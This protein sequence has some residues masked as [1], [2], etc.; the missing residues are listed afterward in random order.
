MMAHFGSGTSAMFDEDVAEP[1]GHDRRAVH[2]LRPLRQDRASK[3]AFGS[4]FIVAGSALQDSELG[5]VANARAR[6]VRAGARRVHE[7]RRARPHAASARSARKCRTS[8]T[9]SSLRATRTSSACRSARSS[10]SFDQDA[11]A[12]WNAN[13]EEGLDDRQGDRRQGGVVGPR[14]RCRPSTC[15][16]GTIMGTGAGEF[17]DQQLRPDPRD[18]QSLDRRARHLPDRAA[19]RTRPTRSSPCRCA[20]PSTSGEVGQRGG[21]GG[22]GAQPRRHWRSSR[23]RRDDR[24]GDVSRARRR[25]EHHR[26]ATSFR[27][28]S[29]ERDAA[30]TPVRRGREPRHALGASRSARG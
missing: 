7:A 29:G 11:V 8:R 19:R 25:Q 5:G 15:M 16:G 24:A 1:H 21:I 27:R 12:L 9:A 17:G 10:H 23:R 3:G 13:F 6:S 2:V 28:R 18:R 22:S 26:S 14:Q 20:A 30:A 4:T